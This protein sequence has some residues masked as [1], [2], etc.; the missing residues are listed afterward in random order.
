MS[1]ITKRGDEGETDLLFG[2]RISKTSARVQVLGTVDE[3]NAA[4]GLARAAGLR[5]DIEPLIDR[6]QEKLVAAMGQLATLPEDQERYAYD[7]VTAVDVVWLE[8]TAHEWEKRGVR[9]TGWARPGAEGAVAA[10]ALDMAR[11]I[12]RRAERQAWELHEQQGMVSEDV[13]LFL[14]RLSDLLWII[15]RVESKKSE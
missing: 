8:E 15:A 9:F 10:A 4:L 13:L 1:I 3:L 2:R 7:K 6:V 12:A 5:D 14:N 11:A